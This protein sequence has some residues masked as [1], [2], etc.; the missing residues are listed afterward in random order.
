MGSFHRTL[1]KYFTR[2]VTI[3]AVAAPP[4]PLRYPIPLVPTLVVLV[5]YVL[6]AVF[7]FIPFIGFFFFI[8]AFIEYGNSGYIGFVMEYVRRDD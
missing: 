7:N 8:H 2:A 3:T 4:H 5:C 1:C 6:G